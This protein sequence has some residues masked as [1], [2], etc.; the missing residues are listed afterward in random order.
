[1][2]CRIG[3]PEHVND[4]NEVGC[5]PCDRV[6]SYDSHLAVRTWC[7]CTIHLLAWPR[8]CW[9]WRVRWHSV[10]L[11]RGC[12]S[13]GLN[14]S[15]GR[16]L[17]PSY[18]DMHACFFSRHHELVALGV[19]LMVP[20]LPTDLGIKCPVRP[21]SFLSSLVGCR[22]EPE[23]ICVICMSHAPCWLLWPTRNHCSLG[24]GKFCGDRWADVARW[25]PTFSVP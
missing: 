9:G 6:D 15:V 24:C 4:W 5:S 21:S 19:L 7:H 23:M 14:A 11:T 18:N 17:V 8:P 2:G 22:G 1:M 20:V 16:L 3:A 13:G 12:M 25:S 10:Q